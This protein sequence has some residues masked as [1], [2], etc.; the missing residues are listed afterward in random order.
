M[1]IASRNLTLRD[2][3]EVIAIPI[4]IYAPE[5]EKSGAWSCRYEIDWPDKKWKMKASG[6]DSVQ[7]IVAALQMIGSEIYS[8]KYHKAGTLSWE[9]P[10]DG[11]GFPVAPSL[12]DLLVGDDAKYL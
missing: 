10:G 6:F 9:K 8:T 3:N 12:R 7:A 11:Y 5:L 4:R 1:I 2:G